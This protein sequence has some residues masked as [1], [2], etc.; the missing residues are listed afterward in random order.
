M[1]KAKSLNVIK[2]HVKHSVPLVTLTTVKTDVDRCITKYFGRL[3]APMDPNRTA[4][5]KKKARGITYFDR[6][7]WSMKTEARTTH[8]SGLPWPR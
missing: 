5:P 8:T 2:P 3:S 7:R 4:R 6:A 1:A